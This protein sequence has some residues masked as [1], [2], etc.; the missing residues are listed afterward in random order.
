MSGPY[1]AYYYPQHAYV[2]I[3]STSI[4]AR[5]PHYRYCMHADEKLS[6]RSSEIIDRRRRS[7][8]C[9]TDDV[10]N[11][12][13][14][15]YAYYYP[16]EEDM[17]SDSSS[18][19]DSNSDVDNYSLDTDV[20]CEE[21]RCLTCGNPGHISRDCA[22]N[23]GYSPRLKRKRQSPETP[24]Q[25]D[26]RLQACGA[27]RQCGHNRRT[28]PTLSAWQYDGDASGEEEAER[29]HV[30][31]KRPRY[32]YAT[33][34]IELTAALLDRRVQVARPAGLSASRAA[35][36]Y[37]RRKRSR[38]YWNSFTLGSGPRG[39]QSGVD[40]WRRRSREKVHVLGS[41]TEDEAES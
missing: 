38:R 20:E 16:T 37:D 33:R 10:E 28:C 39:A 15:T 25:P 7:P 31:V 18:P 41:I 11:M 24:R 30:P 40:V 14:E 4:Q 36:L 29:D 17:K 6:R 32:H 5:G 26:P 35:A 27:C 23:N 34:A 1:V 12:D 9:Y 8:P 2:I 21:E 22:L 3:L 13:E 19:S